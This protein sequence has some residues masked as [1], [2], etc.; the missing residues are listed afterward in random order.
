MKIFQNIYNVPAILGCIIYVFCGSF[1]CCLGVLN[2]EGIRE[3]Y[4]IDGEPDK[5]FIIDICIHCWA[6]PCALCQEKRE[7][8]YH[9]NNI[10]PS[11]NTNMLIVPSNPCSPQQSEHP[12]IMVLA[13]RIDKPIIINASLLDID[14][15]K[16]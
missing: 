3:K 13:S 4:N 9:R 14:S 6:H 11:L 16:E 2:R 10:E 7:L 5:D 12:A 8:D 15:D 1:K